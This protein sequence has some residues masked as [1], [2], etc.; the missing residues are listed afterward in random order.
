MSLPPPLISVIIPVFNGERYLAEAI[1][2]VLAQDYQPLEV[3]VVDDGSSDGSA[4]IGERYTPRVQ[5]YRRAHEGLAAS[6]NAG[7]ALSRG[8]LLAFNDADDV[9]LPGK[10][11]LHASV[12]AAEPA[13]DMVFG[14]VHQFVSPEL[15]DL[16]PAPRL[17]LEPLKGIHVGAM[18][19][20]R[21]A[22][23][24]TGG[25]DPAWRM[26]VMADWFLRASEAGLTHR[27]LP[28]VVLR[29]RVHSNNLTR[30]ERRGYE[31]YLLILKRSLDR[32]RG[33]APAT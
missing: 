24:R 31:E 26:A 33:G 23:L 18:L 7:I 15:E 28:E 5:C 11:S 10:L 2:S 6:T 21:S 17:D 16:R 20:R 32:R 8:P 14:H 22:W 19:L 12:L 3:L 9:W 4:T 30:R 1:E 13:L 29:R 25:F 27:I